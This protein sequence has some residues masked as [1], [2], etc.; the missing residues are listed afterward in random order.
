ML[1]APVKDQNGEI[2]AWL[3][4]VYDITK[5]KQVEKELQ[6]SQEQLR[7]I[8]DSLPVCI[9]YVDAQR[10]YQF[11]NQ[12]YEK[13]FGMRQ[14]EIIGQ[15]VQSI[16]GDVA[17]ASIV[18]L[19]DQV[20][21]GQP[22]TYETLMRYA[23]GGDRYISALLVP[24]GSDTHEVKGYFALVTDVT[25]QKQTET[26][27]R[28][29]LQEKEI[30]LSEVHH[31]VKNNL[32][33]IYS[34]LDL[35]ANRIADPHIQEALRNT[36]G[37]IR[38]MVF[39]HESLYRSQNFASIHLS[40]YIHQLVNHLL[41]TYQPTSREVILCIQVD[42]TLTI[43]L[44]QA[45][46]F[47]LLLNELVTNAIKY[48]LSDGIGRLEVSLEAIADH[49]ELIV[50]N[51]GDTLPPG[52]DFSRVTTMGLRLVL[53]LVEQLHGSVEIERGNRTLFKIIFPK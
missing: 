50:S 49:F 19:L 44:D 11:V 45:I 4:S 34:L 26:V 5:R 39:V 25:S 8:T 42:S 13:W 3:A 37:R 2:I 32:Q 46:P 29:S 9:A 48:G 20:L 35:Q 21:S 47:G 16:I 14:E 33:I 24:D 53:M 52:F 15:P 7:L 6:Q 30:L 38:S 18:K 1:D 17:Y 22:T 27:L 43:G 41:Q 12:T 36:S 28:E 10:R 40:S 51:S 31:R 23:Y